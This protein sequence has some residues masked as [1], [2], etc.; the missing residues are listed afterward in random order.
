[1][2]KLS[3]KD[4][5]ALDKN[6]NKTVKALTRAEPE[7]SKNLNAKASLEAKT[8][9]VKKFARNSKEVREAA[10]KI[11]E[12]ELG[13]SPDGKMVRER[14]L[15]QLERDQA[16]KGVVSEAKT[17]IRDKTK[18]I[19][20]ADIT[21]DDVPLAVNPLF[22]RDLDKAKII[23][24]GS[25]MKLRDASLNKLA[26]AEITEHNLTDQKIDTLIEQGVLNKKEA[27]NLGLAVSLDRFL[28]GN[29]KL[30]EAIIKPANNREGIASLK[31]AASFDKQ[32]WQEFFEKNEL[33]APKGLTVEDYSDVLSQRFAEAFPNEAL[34]A[35]TAKKVPDQ[36]HEA[37]KA[38]APL[39]EKKPDLFLSS[40]EPDFSDLRA[41][42]REKA[43][44]GYKIAHEAD[45]RYP[46]LKL[47]E[48]FQD[49]SIDIDAKTREAG[50]KVEQVKK[51]LELNAEADWV[52]MDYGPESED[53]KELKFDG[54][55]AEIKKATL[56]TMKAYQR[57][58]QVAGSVDLADKLIAAGYHTSARIIADGK[59][60][61]IAKTKL[62]EAV[63]DRVFESAGKA[64][65]GI[66]ASY[67]SI[68]DLVRG[69]FSDLFVGNTGPMIDWQC[70]QSQ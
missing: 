33:E 67:G 17:A 53:V 21:P 62:S 56:N 5:L 55:S 24:I 4:L 3:A 6:K 35:R 28:D 25:T 43:E 34:T 22:K 46:G 40:D 41:D 9:L 11:D 68:L 70:E 63:A 45:S 64:I 36:L 52:S 19:T 15:Q 8:A 49:P 47:R 50:E 58:Y 42:V 7:L 12:R 37:L 1:M 59:K 38:V 44:M 10:A 27:Q 66:T 57:T 69:N 30:I 31:Q 32:Q 23:K 26:D 65:G 29:E 14:L 60:T 13:S 20:P 61:F 48:L 39:L 51:M 54:A 16:D 2:S 18:I